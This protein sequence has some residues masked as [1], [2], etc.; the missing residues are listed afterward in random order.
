MSLPDLQGR[1]IVWCCKVS[2]YSIVSR[3]TGDGLKL[4]FPRYLPQTESRRYTFKQDLLSS[5]RLKGFARHG[6]ANP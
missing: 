4:C 2:S 1:L 5:F 6:C 3:V